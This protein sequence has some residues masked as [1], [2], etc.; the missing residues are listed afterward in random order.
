MVETAATAGRAS[1][2][3]TAA[4]V[5]IVRIVATVTRWAIDLD[6]AVLNAFGPW[7]S[8]P[9]RARRRRSTPLRR[10]GR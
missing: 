8:E 2:G 4:V 9:D 10:R 1:A 6:A 3:R 5:A 7:Q